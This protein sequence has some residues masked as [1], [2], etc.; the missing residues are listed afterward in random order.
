MRRS[1]FVAAIVVGVV[2]IAIAALVMRLTADDGGPTAA[3]WADSVCTSLGD[4]KASIQSIADVGGGTLSTDTLTEKIDAA[5]EATTT[6]VDELETLDRPDL[7]SGEA[8]QEQLSASADELGSSVDQLVEDA[9]TAAQAESPQEFL[10][11]LAKLAP[12][13][14]AL[15]DAPSNALDELR[16]ADVGAAARAELETAFA[17]A[18]SCQELRGDG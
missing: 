5:Q 3:E 14:Q 18:P 17:G 13:F 4:W 9:Q 12:S 1:W 8:L 10:Q 6:L 11:E 16:A 2:S 7:E 15:L